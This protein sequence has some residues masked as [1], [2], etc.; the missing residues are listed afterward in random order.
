[1]PA[2][3]C[4]IEPG[5][6]Q[7]VDQ[8]GDCVDRVRNTRAPFLRGAL[9]LRGAVVGLKAAKAKM[10][11]SCDH[12]RQRRC[13]GV[14][15]DAAARGADVDLDERGQPISSCFGRGFEQLN[16]LGSVDTDSDLGNA[17]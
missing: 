11:A 17:A 3:N 9:M 13:L 1:M 12:F 4:A 6:L 10:S 16:A 5:F 7:V 14:C 8:S 2:D 15:R